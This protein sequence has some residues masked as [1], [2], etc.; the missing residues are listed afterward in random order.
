MVS[1][2]GAQ[3]A[4]GLSGRRAC[5]PRDAVLAPEAIVRQLRPEPPAGD[6]GRRLPRR[7]VSP[8]AL[9]G[10]L[11]LVYPGSALRASWRAREIELLL[12]ALLL[13]ALL[14]Q[15]LAPPAAC[16]AHWP[17][18]RCTA[19]A[20]AA[21]ATTDY[22]GSA[23]HMRKASR[24]GP[25]TSTPRSPRGCRATTGA[26]CPAAATG[27]L[28]APSKAAVQPPAHPRRLTAKQAPPRCR[29]PAAPTLT[30]PGRPASTD[31]ASPPLNAALLLTL[32]HLH[33]LMTI[34]H[35]LRDQLRTLNQHVEKLRGAFCKTVSLALGFVLGSA[36]A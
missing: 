16:W 17:G 1:P 5:L 24:P 19:P 11:S 29:P 8:S 15:A 10:P 22:S 25:S 31:R 2:G 27:G 21:A 13:G 23:S 9:A 28:G 35:P 36:A 20:R 7:P 4:C 12:G 33:L 14:R 26:D 3:S 18:S 6:A 34:L 30:P 32:G